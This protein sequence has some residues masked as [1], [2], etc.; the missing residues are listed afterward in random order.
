MCMVSR[1]DGEQK[2]KQS[3]ED[4][5]PGDSEMAALMRAF[6]WSQ[7]P[8]GSVTQWPQSLRVAVSILLAS[9]FPMQILWGPQYVQF[10]NDSFRPILG[11]KHP[12]SLG[13]KGCDC[14]SEVWDFAGSHLDQVRNTGKA[15]W[16][17][18][19]LLLIDRYG[20]VEECY[21]TFSYT[22]VHDESG[23]VGGI[24]N[25]VNE[26]TQRVVGERR[27]RTENTFFA[28]IAKAKT[29]EE[30]CAIAA[31]VLANNP[32]DIPFAL[33]YLLDVPKQQA[34]LIETVRLQ[35][36]TPASP[37]Y[38]D[39][40]E[41]N[42]PK[43][44]F[45]SQVAFTKVPKLVENLGAEFN[46]LPS[47]PWGIPPDSALVL[48]IATPSQEYP[49]GFIVA[50]ISPYRALDDDY[51]RFLETITSHIAIALANIRAYEEER[52]RAEALAELDQA[53]TV[54]FSNVSHEFRTPL[55]LMVGPLEDI[56]TNEPNYLPPSVNEQLE[57]VH[58]NAL[59]LQKL[60]NNLLDFSRLEAG[61]IQ[62]VYEP[63]N[64][65]TFT[66]ELASVFRSTIEQAGIK[67]LIDCPP[68]SQPVYVDREMWEKIVFNLLSNAFK[69]TL[70]GEI[71]ISLHPSNISVHQHGSLHTQGNPPSGLPPAYTP[72]VQS[73]T[74]GNPPAGLSHRN[75]LPRA[76]AVQNP[77][78]VSL[79]VKDTGIGIP[80]EE[81]PHL[82]ERF[83]RV[84]NSQ[85]RTYE[86]SGIGLSLVQEFV[87]L[88]SG[89]V[90]V[91]SVEGKGSCFTVI[92]P[93]GSAHLPPE[94]ISAT[95]TSV[96]TRL[97]A[98]A[99]MEEALRCL[100]EESRGSRGSTGEGEAE[101]AGGAGEQGRNNENIPPSLPPRILLVD[102]NADM[103][104][105]VKGLLSQ[106]YEVEAVNDGLAALAAVRQQL[107]DL[108]LTDVMMP[109][110]DG[111][112]LLRQLRADPNTREIPIILLSARAGEESRL[113]GLQA[114][115]DDYLIKPF[116]ARELLARINAHLKLVKFR[117]EAVSRELQLLM[118][119]ERLHIALKNSPVSVFNQDTELRY[120]WEYNPNFEY[121]TEAVIGKRD[122][123]LLSHD[124]AQALTQIK[125]RVLETGIGAREEVKM[126]L[127]GQ[128][129]YYDLTVEPLRNANNQIIGITCA[130][131]DISERKQAEM[132]LRQS[133]Q[134]LRVALQ[135]EQVSRTEAEAANRIKD[136]FLAVLSHELRTP[137]NPILGWAKMLRSR[138]FDAKATDRALET[139]ERNAKLQVQLIEDL[140]D[141]S[142]ILRGKLSLN[143]CPI[144]LVTTIDAAIETVR[145]A[146]QAKEIQIETFLDSNVGLV[147]GDTNRL[148]QV[149]WNLL[150]N[151]VKFTPSGGKVEVRLESTFAVYAQITIKDTGIGINPEFLPYV[152]E[153]FRQ[154]NSAT[155]RKFG[156]L[157]LGLAIVRYLTELHGGAVKAESPGIG[158]GAVF[159]VTL[160][161]MNSPKSQHLS[162]FLNSHYAQT[163]PPLPTP[164]IRLNNV[165]ALIIDDE[166]DLR[167]LITLILQESGAR[168]TATASVAEALNAL[169]HSVPDVLISDIGMPDVDGYMLMHQIRALSPEQGGLVPA[170]ALTA[171]A[172]EYNQKQALAAGYQ[173]HI[174]KPVEPDT[175]IKAIASLV[176]R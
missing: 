117:K 144:N 45:L 121:E 100:P 127:E 167:E 58:R 124:D 131:V 50:G 112:E 81:I 69:Y 157:G 109:R 119:E 1:F 89:T 79:E 111:L 105:Y 133:E 14:W 36:N 74:A 164:H 42:S 130:A 116:S 54:F 93:T 96:S 12:K 154:E 23:T 132:A 95:R 13:Q 17:D 97:G 86:G 63:T 84:K 80:P 55:T 32:A 56:L 46:F 103:R 98:A 26:T 21:F 88:H 33:L 15:S 159:T 3:L 20:Y 53:K 161:L 142:R 7:T 85:G 62:A 68:L 163:Q 30:V 110:L 156:G 99:Y 149:V 87:R 2:G 155:T 128:D 6:D 41:E 52:K 22:P 176:Q 175:L 91:Q 114:T 76:S 61:R 136:E 11:T 44:W 27:H 72:C 31:G 77:E 83:H 166:A 170:I 143:I 101:E 51:H 153:Y 129:C 40:A 152:F 108:V 113:E 18:D 141:V 38:I 171:Y 57:M 78:S 134:Q 172:G 28:Q 66:A 135:R 24:F 120:T 160:P 59:R 115:A 138:K 147:L 48:P 34:R 47:E 9:R 90:Q 92:I 106:H 37:D 75:A 122:V 29:A 137:L 150:S 49:A 5:F 139:I 94:R 25:A 19:Q 148:Q 60:V 67:L 73:P 107:P 10:Y 173:L 104:D 168:V 125:R 126:T 39:L 145:L 140:L 71:I 102:D 35:P 4:V 123:D 118:S 158:L 162:S 165:H 70:V 8:L 16:S 151:A 64:L 146:A 43:T 65:S 174:S 82:F 169:Q